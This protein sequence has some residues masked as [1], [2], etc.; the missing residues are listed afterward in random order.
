MAPALLQVSNWRQAWGGVGTRHAGLP[1]AVAAIRRSYL[2]QGTV[3]LICAL[4][5]YR[6]TANFSHR[7][8]EMYPGTCRCGHCRQPISPS[9]SPA[10]ESFSQVEGDPRPY[11]PACARLLAAPRCHVCAQHVPV[12]EEGEVCYCENDF[13]EQPFCGEHDPQEVQRLCCWTCRRLP[14]PGGWGGI[15]VWGCV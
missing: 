7:T 14:E 4:Q 8:P 13:W 10:A 3:S 9:G 5:L 11:H 2:T 6:A 12:N 15:M 1:S